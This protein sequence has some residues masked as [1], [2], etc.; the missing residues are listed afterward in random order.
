MPELPD[1]ELYLHALRP[2]LVG[3]R[4]AGVR[5]ASPFLVRSI[6]P[7]V[8]TIIHREI[9]DLRRL[10]KRI[11]WDLGD[12]L[13]AI[14]HLMIAGRFRWKAR[15][16]SIPGK[17]GLAAFDFAAG[18]LVLTEAGSK[19]QASLYV[20]RGD[21]AL[22]DHDPGGLEVLEATPDQFAAA[23]RRENHTIK[24]ALTDPHLLSGIGNAYS[25]EILHAA[26]MSPMKLTAQMTER[27]L[28][29]LHA[30]TVTT[31]RTWRDRL[32]VE[33]GG[34][35]PEKVTAFREGMAVHGRFGKP[36]P[37][38]GT[39]VQRIRYAANEANYCPTCQTG[40]KLL[41]DR[42]LSRLLKDDWP[43]SLEELERRKAAGVR[44]R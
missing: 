12:S 39:P 29:A 5:L 17:V 42:S 21:E 1:I 14:F 19:R 2:R 35:F 6:D 27:E 16:A 3:Q 13:F 31:L 34:L 22:N 15:G 43:R 7:P 26:R 8:D 38:C 24:R 11:V 28:A 9:H 40:G 18:T 44:G 4:V 36:C 23:L 32:I 10:G 30:V 33:A 41:A 37:A 25:D 20:V